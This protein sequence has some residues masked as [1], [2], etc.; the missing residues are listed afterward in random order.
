MGHATLTPQKTTN[1]KSGHVVDVLVVEAQQI[2]R[3]EFNFLPALKEYPL[4]PCVPVAK[5]MT[6]FIAREKK[7]PFKTS[8]QA[9]PL[10]ASQVQYFRLFAP[11]QSQPTSLLNNP[12]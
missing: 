6:L 1:R 5:F 2:S 3:I 10:R 11:C 7:R 9:R 8:K 4:V 12:K